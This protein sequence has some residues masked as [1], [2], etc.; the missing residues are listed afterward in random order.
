MRHVGYISF[1]VALSWMAITPTF[2]L[3]AFAQDIPEPQRYGGSSQDY[4]AQFPQV[5]EELN[6]FWGGIFAAAGVAYR[7][8]SVVTLDEPTSTA[9]GAAGPE[10]F[11][12]YCPSDE[13]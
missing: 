12:F 3:P 10:G 7:A 5:F 2:A 6:A 8:P 13:T 1:V 11:A 9:C 4:T